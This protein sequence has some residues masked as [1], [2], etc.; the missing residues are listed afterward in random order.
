MDLHINASLPLYIPLDLELVRDVETADSSYLLA[1]Q[2]VNTAIE[3]VSAQAKAYIDF[4]LSDNNTAQVQVN[5]QTLD[6]LLETLRQHIVSKHELEWWKLSAH[7]SRAKIRQNQRT[8]PELTLE[9]LDSYREY[10]DRPQFGDQIIADY[11]EERQ[12]RQHEKTTDQLVRSNVI[13]QQLQ[14]LVFILQDPSNPL[15]T[16]ADSDD[17][18]MAGGK[19]S[20][21][22]PLSL[23]YYVE[24]YISR[25]CLH[26]FSKS[27]IYEYLDGTNARRQENCP[28]DGCNATLSLN[29]MQPDLIMQLRMKVY[30]KKGREQRENIERI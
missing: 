16:D 11:Q 2:E 18:E 14:N 10:A 17:L 8:E 6:T 29:D 19:I 9:T 4:V 27:T 28:V 23:D 13:Y 30:R 21:R 12:L 5:Q 15:P 25:K 22:D 20:L 1:L 7:N 3:D 26:V 24:P